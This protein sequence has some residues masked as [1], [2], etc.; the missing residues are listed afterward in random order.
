MGHHD[1]SHGPAGAD[2]KKAL[3]IVLVLTTCFMF[4]EAGAGFYT[5][6]P[7]AL[8]GCCPY[9]DRCICALNCIYRHMD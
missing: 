3:S 2:Q 5:G 4:I 6:K 7:G 9:A 1:H 8:V